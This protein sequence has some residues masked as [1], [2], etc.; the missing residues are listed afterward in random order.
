MTLRQL[1]CD[2]ILYKMLLNR[3]CQRRYQKP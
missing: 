2:N 3:R 1:K